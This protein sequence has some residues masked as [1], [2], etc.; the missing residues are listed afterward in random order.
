MSTEAG[1]AARELERVIEHLPLVD[2]HVH[3]AASVP[4]DRTRFETLITESDRPIPSFMTQFDSQIGFAIR[5]WCSPVLGLPP[6]ADPDDYLARRAELGTA[7]VNRRLLAAAGIGR[8][9]IET[10]YRGDDVLG[11]ERMAEVS[12]R[13]ADEIVRIEKVMEEVA[14]SGTTAADFPSGSA[15]R[16][17]RVRP[18]RWG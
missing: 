7:E 5:R 15:P 1:V 13:P 11:P 12:G 3:G 14:S 2:H 6:H 10:G 18:R 16:S 9:L 4:L 8:W 17:R